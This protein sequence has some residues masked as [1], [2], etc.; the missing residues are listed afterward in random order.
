[1]HYLLHFAETCLLIFVFSPYAGGIDGGAG[2]RVHEAPSLRNIH[3][4]EDVA[5]EPGW[6]QNVSWGYYQ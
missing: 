3:T 6:K 4:A 1:M 2:G 5:W